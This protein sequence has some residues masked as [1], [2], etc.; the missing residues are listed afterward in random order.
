MTSPFAFQGGT[1]AHLSPQECNAIVGAAPEP[2]ATF[3]DLLWQTGLRVSE[4]L[5]VRKDDIGED[6]LRVRRLK[7]SKEFVD[8]V[9]LQAALRARLL[10][11]RA[12]KGRP[13]FPYS[14]SGAWRALRSAAVKAGIDPH[15]VHPHIFRHS[16]AIFM[17][18]ELERVMP[19]LAAR[20]VLQALLGHANAATTD[21][22]LRRNWEEVVE[23]H[24]QVRFR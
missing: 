20:S 9:P 1:P 17:G 6:W 16:F 22:Y 21:V 19:H 23:A 4:A 15:T 7:R 3:F 2:W 12:G 14:R 13:L 24:R 5:G 11:R 18:E 8:R 10:L